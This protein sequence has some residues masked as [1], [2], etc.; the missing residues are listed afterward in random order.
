[1]RCLEHDLDKCL[2]ALRFPLIHRRQIRATNLL[3][4][5]LGEGKRRSKVIPRFT[6]EA[7]GLS[8]V[9][10]V[11]V[12]AAEGWRGVRM[13]ADLV[14]RLKQLALDPDSSWNDPDLEKLAA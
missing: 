10:A 4:R 11:L 9:F 5:L 8:L 3:E 6:S 13:R 2:S 1:M 14:A 7:G 12:D